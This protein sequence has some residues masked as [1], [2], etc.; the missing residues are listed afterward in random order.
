METKYRSFAF[1]NLFD[2]TQLLSLCLIGIPKGLSVV[3]AFEAYRSSAQ[4][5]SYK[6]RNVTYDNVE[7]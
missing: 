5:V 2:A 6:R 7:G 3:W 1:Y 4:G